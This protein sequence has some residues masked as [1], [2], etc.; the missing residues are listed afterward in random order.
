MMAKQAVASTSCSVIA[1]RKKSM[2]G[3]NRAC[4][5]KLVTCLPRESSI[6]NH[7]IPLRILFWYEDPSSLKEDVSR[8]LK[9]VVERPFLCLNKELFERAEW[10]DIVICLAFPPSMFINTRALFHKWLLLTFPSIL[11]SDAVSFLTPGDL[12]RSMSFLPV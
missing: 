11:L 8:I 6:E 4:V 1:P 3:R 2:D 9:Y 12:L 10:R 7:E 5:S